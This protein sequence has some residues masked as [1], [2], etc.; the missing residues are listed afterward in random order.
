MRLA[1]Q[2]GTTRVPVTVWNAMGKPV[3]AYL[4]HVLRQLGYQVILR[5]VPFGHMGAVAGDSRHKAQLGTAGWAQEIPSSADFFVP[6]LTCH[7]FYQDPTRT[8]NWAEFCD[9]HADQLVNAAQAAQQTDPA[10]AR[11]LWAQ[12]DRAVTGQAPWVPLFNPSWA[13]FVSARVGNCQ[14]SP[15]Y[16]GPLLDQ[17]WVR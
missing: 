16:A 11:R 7:S 13:W 3:G 2:S 17:M 8:A 14:E 10:A 12:A 6:E 5:A 1:H 15:E 9:P 4:V